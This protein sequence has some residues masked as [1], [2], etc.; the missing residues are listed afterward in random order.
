MAGD[1]R[2]IYANSTMGSVQNLEQKRSF[3]NLKIL[4][5]ET[6]NNLY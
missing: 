6:G 2:Q 1:L 4:K 3:K 5:V